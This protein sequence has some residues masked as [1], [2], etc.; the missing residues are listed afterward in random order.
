MSLENLIVSEIRDNGPI[1]IYRFME[2]CLYNDQFGYYSSKKNLIGA[3]GDFITS[4][5]IS[6]VFGE[7]YID[8]RYFKNTS[9]YPK[10]SKFGIDISSRNLSRLTSPT[11]NPLKKLFNPMG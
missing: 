10:P 5:E 9:Y 3:T 7:W 11:S 8:E 2:E 1:S 4:P 6:Q